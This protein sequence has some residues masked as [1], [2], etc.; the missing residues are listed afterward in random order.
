MHVHVHVVPRMEEDAL[1]KFPP[2]GGML[3]KEVAAEV[4]DAIKANLV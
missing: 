2:S 3:A 1:I 4:L